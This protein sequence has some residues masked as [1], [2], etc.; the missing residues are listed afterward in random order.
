M[1]YTI[2]FSSIQL[3]MKFLK[4]V[5][6]LFILDGL[7][8]CVFFLGGGLG[9]GYAWGNSLKDQSSA[10]LTPLSQWVSMA[11]ERSP[12]HQKLK[13]QTKMMQWEGNQGWLNLL[14]TL[15]LNAQHVFQKKYQVLDVNLGGISASLPQ[16]YPTTTTGLEARWTLFDG[17]ANIVVLRASSHLNQAAEHQ[18]IWLEFKMEREVALSYAQ[19]IAAQQ[20][21]AV[22]VMNLKTL[23]E[24]VQQIQLLKKGGLATHYDELKVQT[25]ISEAEAE[26]LQALDNSQIALMNFKQTLGGLAEDSPILPSDL[27]EFQSYFKPDVQN[28]V[29]DLTYHPEYR[30]DLASLEKQEM[31]EESL[32]SAKN[33]YWV[34][35]IGLSARLDYYNNQT[36]GLADW[37]HYRQA[38]NIAA[39]LSWELFNP[40]TLTNAKI[41]T[42]STEMSRHQLEVTQLKAPV[43][44]EFWK[45]RYLYSLKLYQAKKTDVERAQ[46]TVRLAQVGFKAGVRT[47][48]EVLDSELELFRARAGLVHAEMNGIEAV[49]KL[50]LTSGITL[51]Q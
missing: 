14:P 4:Q 34:P 47:S 5:F 32:T 39:F 22:S 9:D 50:E 28:K 38:Y 33:R 46:E 7:C 25:Q 30:E 44:F 3:I 24:H 17:F 11:Q 2:L 13:A 18:A 21:E 41:Q 48:S 20:L 31:A 49:L 8:L 1:F 15:T 10:R 29:K 16:I 27:S 35:R 36:D 19:A 6:S 42:Y 23:Q 12:D 37:N 43:D 45:K 51:K 40:R 26:H